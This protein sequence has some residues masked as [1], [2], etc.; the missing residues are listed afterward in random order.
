MILI[1]YHVNKGIVVLPKSVTEKRISS[2]KEVIS[3]SKEDLD[4]RDGL[5]AKGKAKRINTPLWGFDRGFADW[6]APIKSQ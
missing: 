4:L 2:N 5:A 6:Y 1:S 3:L